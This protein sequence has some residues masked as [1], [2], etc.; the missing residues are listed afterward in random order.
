MAGVRPL[1]G[2][3]ESAGMGDPAGVGGV[4]VRVVRVPLRRVAAVTSWPVA[5][6]AL[7]ARILKAAVP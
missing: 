5:V 6:T 2:V 4:T 1:A 7:A 3:K